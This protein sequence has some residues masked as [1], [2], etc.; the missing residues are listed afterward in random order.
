MTRELLATELCRRCDPATIPFATSADDATPL[1]PLGQD[2]ALEAARFAFA[3]RHEGYNLFALGPP[4]LGKRTA[5]EALL[6][7]EAAA[8]PTPDDWCYVHDVRAARRPR[9]LRMPPGA[10]TRLRVGMER[11]VEE[12]EVAM[13]AAFESEEYRTRKQRLARELGQRQE[14]AFELLQQRARGLR[15]VVERTDTGV[16]VAPSRAASRSTPRRSPGCRRTS[17]RRCGRRSRRSVPR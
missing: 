2:R 7:T 8:Q 11:A 17:S 9:A 5:I 6:A 15:V 13:P 14:A 10:A 3:M 16:V 1:A 12:L 4:G